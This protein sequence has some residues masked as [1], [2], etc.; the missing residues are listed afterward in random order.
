M[1][2][3]RSDMMAD[4]AEME[5]SGRIATWPSEASKYKM[6][7]AFTDGENLVGCQRWT[8]SES[9]GR[10]SQTEQ[11]GVWWASNGPSLD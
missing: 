3:I 2:S 4:G 7:K 6:P 1:E 9:E 5:T 11:T 8:S 10:N